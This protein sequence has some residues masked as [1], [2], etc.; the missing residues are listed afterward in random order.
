MSETLPKTRNELI[1]IYQ[2]FPH[3]SRDSEIIK[4]V[5]PHANSP[6]LTYLLAD[7]LTESHPTSLDPR[8]TQE[9]VWLP[10]LSDDGSR[11][12][13]LLQN[14]KFPSLVD[15]SNFTQRKIA[16]TIAL[17]LK[18]SQIPLLLNELKSSIVTDKFALAQHCAK[19]ASN[20]QLN[21]I[22]PDCSFHT[23]L[24]IKNELKKLKSEKHPVNVNHVE[25]LEKALELAQLNE[26]NQLWSKLYFF[27][28]DGE[29]DRVFDLQ[30]KYPPVRDL[31]IKSPMLAS[32][33]NV[34][35]NEFM[36]SNH[37]CIRLF[38]LIKDTCLYTDNNGNLQYDLPSNLT[39]KKRILN[40]ISRNENLGYLV[41]EILECLIQSKVKVS[42]K[43]DIKLLLG[44]LRSEK[45]MDLAEHA[46]NWKTDGIPDKKSTSVKY[47][48]FQLAI[49]ILNI[50][51]VRLSLTSSIRDK[52]LAWKEFTEKCMILFN[53]ILDNGFEVVR[54]LSIGYQIQFI[55]NL[56]TILIIPLSGIKNLPILAEIFFEKISVIFINLAPISVPDSDGGKPKRVDDLWEVLNSFLTMLKPSR[57]IPSVYYDLNNNRNKEK[58]IDDFDELYPPAQI[59]WSNEKVFRAAIDLQKK[60]EYE[61]TNRRI[62][63]SSVFWWLNL[64]HV[65]TVDQRKEVFDLFGMDTL[66][67]IADHVLAEVLRKFPDPVARGKMVME[68]L[69]SSERVL[70]LDSFLFLPDP[71][72]REVLQQKAYARS[73]EDREK[74]L[75]NLLKATL[76]E[77]ILGYWWSGIGHSRQYE[78]GENNLLEI[79][80]GLVTEWIK[81]IRFISDRIKNEILPNVED[82]FYSSFLSK[83]VRGMQLDLATNKETRD[84]I[85]IY[86]L[87]ENK[88]ANAV[89]KVKCVSKFINNIAEESIRRFAH[90]PDHP[91]FQ[92]GAEILWKNL[93]YEHGENDVS[94]TLYDIT[95]KLNSDW[96]PALFT[97]NNNDIDERVDEREEKRRL[98]AFLLKNIFEE[99]DNVGK[100]KRKWGSIWVPSDAEGTGV[101][102]EKFVSAVLELYSKHS[103]AFYESS[104]GK[105]NLG[106]NDEHLEQWK[107]IFLVL[108]A[109]WDR[110]KI[111]CQFVD[112]MI[113]RLKNT[114]KIFT[115]PLSENNVNQEK[116]AVLDWRSDNAKRSWKFFLEVLE[117]CYI[118]HKL[119]KSQPW[120]KIIHDLALRSTN[121]IVEAEYRLSEFESIDKLTENLLEISESALTLSFVR[122]C[123]TETRLDLLEDRFLSPDYEGEWGVF[124]I[125]F[126]PEIGQPEPK[127]VWIDFKPSKP[128]RLSSNQCKILSQRLRK[129][130]IASNIGVEER[131]ECMERLVKLPTTKISD[132]CD[133][134]HEGAFLGRDSK[135]ENSEDLHSGAL[136]NDLFPQRLV[137]AALMFCA[138]LPEPLGA[139]D[140]LLCLV[141]LKSDLSRTAI[142]VLKQAL[143]HLQNINIVGDLIGPLLL[144]EQKPLK[145]TVM[146]ELV[147]IAFQYVN[148]STKC[149]EVLEKV[150]EKGSQGSLHRDVAIVILQGAVGLLSMENKN[151][152]SK[153]SEDLAWKMIKTAA[154][155]PWFRLNDITWVLLAITKPTKFMLESLDKNGKPEYESAF[156]SSKTLVNLGLSQSPPITMFAELARQTIKPQHL[157]RYLDEGLRPLYR[158]LFN[159]EDGLKYIETLKHNM[160]TPSPPIAQQKH[161]FR[162]SQ[163]TLRLVALEIVIAQWVSTTNAVELSNEFSSIACE[164]M[165]SF[166][167][168][169]LEKTHIDAQEKEMKDMFEKCFKWCARGIDNLMERLFQ[170]Q[171]VNSITRTL[172]KSDYESQMLD[173]KLCCV[174]GNIVKIVEYLCSLTTLDWNR[175]G[176]SLKMLKWLDLGCSNW[177]F[178]S[179]SWKFVE[180]PILSNQL[181]KHQPL[182]FDVLN[183]I[184]KP[185]IDFNLKNEMWDVLWWRRIN[186][187]K[188]L[189]TRIS[190]VILSKEETISMDKSHAK[191]LLPIALELIDDLCLN[192]VKNRLLSLIEFNNQLEK[193]FSGLNCHLQSLILK[194]VFDGIVKKSNGFQKDSFVW[195]VPSSSFDFFEDT[196]QKL[197]LVN[198]LRIWA[199]HQ[200]AVSTILE[201]P[202]YLKQFIENHVFSHEN[203]N[204]S[205]NYMISLKSLKKP[206]VEALKPRLPKSWSLNRVIWYTPVELIAFSEDLISPIAERAR[207]KGWIGDEADVLWYLLEEDASLVAVRVYD[208]AELV[209]A[210]KRAISDSESKFTD[211]HSEK[212]FN[213]LACFIENAVVATIVDCSSNNRYKEYLLA[214]SNRFNNVRLS[215]LDESEATLILK[216]FNKRH[217]AFMTSYTLLNHNLSIPR[218]LFLESLIAGR[219]EQMN[220]A[221]LIEMVKLA[222]TTGNFSKRSAH[223]PDLVNAIGVLFPFDLTSG[224]PEDRITKNTIVKLAKRF[225]NLF[226]GHYSEFYNI[227]AT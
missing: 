153:E 145:V 14:V 48:R 157:Q 210:R 98:R 147:R 84:L 72:Q 78:N 97:S 198:H 57:P 151:Q 217:A 87:M 150:W 167:S 96:F 62:S 106:F 199:F 193:F 82:L 138:Q 20:D 163:C 80:D 208:I 135:D 213:N 179:H 81:T 13:W 143:P 141:Y 218:I 169:E 207:S 85:K 54:T 103:N 8:R 186:F 111:L 136:G 219:F 165:N 166:L 44:R 133:L 204:K 26:R 122:N 200:T 206:L 114:P 201:S 23:Q 121:S 158:H 108:G 196:S 183:S 164:S 139:I 83:S 94:K 18:D 4:V 115:L 132:I 63:D 113:E 221:P 16:L 37:Y 104:F 71:T 66:K 49:N 142:H 75:I 134:L 68:L 88:N 25:L 17:N 105:F 51:L 173:Q 9:S 3:K 27:Q 32:V 189:K 11:S 34:Y 194:A 86:S 155:D 187:M 5:L 159:I 212:I 36:T 176:S 152:M 56:K 174:F 129:R 100:I 58:N 130:I 123:L 220:L 43:E 146:K 197:I 46:L 69:S 10:I 216:S 215:V 77:N 91:F 21:E 93:I 47:D 148:E 144:S 107:G 225:E 192:F 190:E 74:A 175:R 2:S 35:F 170:P 118:D 195:P 226:T 181:Y 178:Y 90:N 191:R 140:L 76:P 7:L 177:Y 101:P 222:A 185:L 28:I 19:Y 124:Q 171:T 61:Q 52:S 156:I 29:V 119:R 172:P 40:R 205:S 22:L 126:P 227:I 67:I 89:S 31:Q 30:Q 116:Q 162:K 117:P 180:T 38:G 60:S 120:F 211:S 128:E 209:A 64:A 92:F 168:F 223:A 41:Y 55:N 214:A 65:L 1:K 224:D 70:D 110:V 59:K 154:I 202:W 73:W 149:R 102:E 53:K 127:K 79:T 188:Q 15:R 12:D 6:E 95:S 24:L 42:L 160:K 50:L 203:E 125:F 131:K 45:L 109:R 161:I 137:E 184:L 112:Y 39:R 182:A 33:F 99:K